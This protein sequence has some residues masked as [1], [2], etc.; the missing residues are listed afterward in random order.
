MCLFRIHFSC[1]GYDV[2]IFRGGIEYS[3][4]LFFFSLSFRIIRWLFCVKCTIV[5]ITHTQCALCKPTRKFKVVSFVVFFFVCIF[6]Y[7][8]TKKFVKKVHKR[9]RFIETL[10]EKHCS[11]DTIKQ[12][13]LIIFFF[14]VALIPIGVDIEFSFINICAIET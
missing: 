7:L 4:S 11:K 3:S 2:G 5:A 10:A 12:N 8:T 13:C 1:S 14:R 6:L 9:A